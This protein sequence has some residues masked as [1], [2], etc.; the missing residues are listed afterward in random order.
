[1]YD[2]LDGILFSCARGDIRT[3]MYRLMYCT[4]KCKLRK[5]GSPTLLM[6]LRNGMTSSSIL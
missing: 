6:I 1:M 2:G 4:S 3:K 5:D